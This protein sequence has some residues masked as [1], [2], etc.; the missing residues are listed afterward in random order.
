MCD[1]MRGI[2]AR[3][4]MGGFETGKPWVS[5]MGQLQVNL[6]IFILVRPRVRDTPPPR[7]SASNT[8]ID[9]ILIG[10]SI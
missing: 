3:D 6:Y 7:T 5:P 8:A 1:A 10:L 2:I 9:F 4:N